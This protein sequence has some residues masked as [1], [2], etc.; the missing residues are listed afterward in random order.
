MK[1]KRTVKLIEFEIQYIAM[2]CG[3]MAQISPVHNEVV[4]ARLE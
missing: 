3:H 1:I 2:M 4:Q